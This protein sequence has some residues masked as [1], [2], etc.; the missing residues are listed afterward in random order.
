LEINGRFVIPKRTSGSVFP[1][2]SKRI[3]GLRTASSASH[4]PAHWH[5]QVKWLPPEPCNFCIN[6]KAFFWKLDR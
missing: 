1:I 2:E 4:L 6:Q 5:H 3:G